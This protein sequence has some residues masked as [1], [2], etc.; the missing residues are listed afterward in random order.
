MLLRGESCGCGVTLIMAKQFRNYL[1]EA[2]RSFLVFESFHIDIIDE[3]SLRLSHNNKLTIVFDKSLKLSHTNFIAESFLI[4]NI[5]PCQR[6]PSHSMTDTRGDP[7]HESTF[8]EFLVFVF[9]PDGR[10]SKLSKRSE[11]NCKREEFSMMN[12][13]LMARRGRRDEKFSLPIEWFQF[14]SGTFSSVSKADCTKRK[15][16]KQKRSEPVGKYY[17]RWFK[18]HRGQI[19]YIIKLL[20]K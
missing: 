1:W 4:T 17:M 8:I 7:I 20:I 2:I 5:S 9:V 16:K 13:Q 19:E 6:S 18:A 14:F 3:S 11:M 15:E 10:K 12:F